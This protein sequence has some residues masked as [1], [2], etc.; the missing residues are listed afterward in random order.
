MDFWHRQIVK[1]ARYGTMKRNLIIVGVIALI[2]ALS[3]LLSSRQAALQQKRVEIRS[4]HILVRVDR[5]DPV[6]QAQ[7][8]EKIKEVHER[9][10]AGEDFAE[11]AK[12][13]SEDVMSAPLGGD[14]GF[15]ETDDLDDE[16][17]DIVLN[18]EEGEASDIVETSY[19][20]HIIELLDKKEPR[21]KR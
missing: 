8:L 21:T 20:Y 7:A 19:G 10:L 17:R 18:L 2:F 15:I 13:Y 16:Y 6:K 5:N 3:I 12:Q 11:L 9:L 14:L 1:E 4:R